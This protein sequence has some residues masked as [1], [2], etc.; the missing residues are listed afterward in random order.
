MKAGKITT[1]LLILIT[2]SG[3]L[4][5]QEKELYIK[6]KYN[7]KG[8]ESISKGLLYREASFKTYGEIELFSY[9]NKIKSRK[10]GGISNTT[11][12]DGNVI[13]SDTLFYYTVI[14]YTKGHLLISDDLPAA[15]TAQFLLKEPLNLFK[16]KPCMDTKTILGY[17]CHKATCSFRGR[18]YVAWFTRDIPF[19]AAPWKFHGL[20]GAILEV[21]P[22][23][24]YCSWV[25]ESLEIRPFKKEI[26]L[27]FYGWDI[28]DMDKYMQI[29]KKK[30]QVNLKILK[31]F[32]Y[33]EE[34]ISKRL[35]AI[36]IFDLD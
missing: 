18:E 36:E 19:K 20:P 26:E 12:A 29:L 15:G 28:V 33:S 25:A 32:G 11:D 31:G 21:Y 22:T 3:S 23:D 7:R 35:K 10:N 1:L 16:W 30:K 17:T 13:A 2:I 24:G 34:Q 5:A 4:F 9:G 27:P 8:A 14:D 6:Y